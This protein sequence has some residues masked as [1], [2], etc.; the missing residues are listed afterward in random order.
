MSVAAR[1]SVFYWSFGLEGKALN[2]L[3]KVLLLKT[4]S[5]SR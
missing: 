4:I 5:R 1:G 2:N 3:D